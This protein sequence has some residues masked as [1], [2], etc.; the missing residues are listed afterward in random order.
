LDFVEQLPTTVKDVVLARCCMAFDRLQPDPQQDLSATFRA[1]IV[2]GDDGQT[3]YTCAQMAAVLELIL[4]SPEARLPRGGCEAATG[5]R[6]GGTWGSPL[7]QKHWS[8]AQDDFARLRTTALHPQSLRMMLIRDS[9]A[10]AVNVHRPRPDSGD[11][12]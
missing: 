4:C 12:D 6:L 7:A 9:E 11:T 2:S 1:I 8:A 3:A 10:K 5:Q